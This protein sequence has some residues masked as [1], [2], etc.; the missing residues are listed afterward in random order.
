MDSTIYM[1]NLTCNKYTVG[2]LRITLVNDMAALDSFM[3]A[4]I[5]AVLGFVNQLPHASTS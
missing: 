5:H 4:L 2:D 3:L 1:G